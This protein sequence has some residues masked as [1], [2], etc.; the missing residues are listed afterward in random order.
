MY[1]TNVTPRFG[2]I[3]ALLHINNM[4]PGGWFELARN[5]I[6]KMFNPAMEIKREVFPL[7][8]VHTDYDFV[9]QLYYNNDVEIR[10]WISHIGTKSFTVHHEA[11]QQDRLCVK[12]NAVVVHYDFNTEE[13]IP[14]PEDK[15]QL[16][17]EHLYKPET[18][19]D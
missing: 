17:A 8:L 1:T 13:S 6:I 16:L 11:W 9:G 7:V 10:T 14:I 18:G 4:V 15:K 19:G 2:D 3:D 12:G 5:K